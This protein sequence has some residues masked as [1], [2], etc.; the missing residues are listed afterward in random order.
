MI[1]YVLQIWPIQK[2]LIFLFLTILCNTEKFWVIFSS[3]VQNVTILSNIAKGI[4]QN[5]QILYNTVLGNIAQ[6]LQVS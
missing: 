4:A 5:L 6:N 3:I 1:M 2:G